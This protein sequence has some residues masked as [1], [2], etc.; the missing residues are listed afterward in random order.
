[1]NYKI[2]TAFGIFSVLVLT[3]TESLAEKRKSSTQSTGEPELKR[4]KKETI[5]F[6]NGESAKIAIV[7]NKDVITYQDIKER[8]LLILMTSGVESTPE[9]IKTVTIDDV[10]G[11][12]VDGELNTT[13][14][15]SIGFKLGAG[16]KNPN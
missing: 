3:T 7:V 5:N 15:E 8:A 10:K 4:Q 13:A 14:R 16:N 12:T 1:M 2:L 11:F 9:M 6:I